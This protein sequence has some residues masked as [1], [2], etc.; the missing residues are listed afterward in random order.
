MRTILAKI[1]IS[2]R[3][4][5]VL[6]CLLVCGLVGAP[7]HSGDA[8]KSAAVGAK[9]A[10]KSV[11]VFHQKTANIGNAEF[12]LADD[13]ACLIAHNGDNI[14]IAKAPTWDVILYSKQKKLGYSVSMAKIAGD[15]MGIFKPPLSLIGGKIS[16]CSEPRFGFHRRQLVVHATKSAPVE[17]DPFFF[18]KTAKPKIVKDV[19]FYC[20]DLGKIDPKCERFIQWVYS[21]IQ[22]P[23]MPLELTAHYTDGSHTS[24]YETLSVEKTTRPV[25][26]FTYPTG[27]KKSADKINIFASAD[28]QSTLEDLFG[29]VKEK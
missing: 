14:A 17:K 25:S 21:E 7:A 29:S 5:F 26:F 12:Y 19:V 4:G 27:F 28:A 18:Q 10:V 22:L 8:S 16:E 2:T 23:G 20:A 15:H 13:A 11:T 24:Q 1:R 9:P 6:F 3:E